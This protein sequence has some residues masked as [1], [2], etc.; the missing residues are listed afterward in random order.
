MLRRDQMALPMLQV[1]R[2]AQRDWS[3][4]PSQGNMLSS[5]EGLVPVG[6][7]GFMLRHRLYRHLAHPN[8][9][10]RQRNPW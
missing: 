1:R 6:V 4:D 2:R 8:D 3:V 7:I 5:L 10:E 9:S